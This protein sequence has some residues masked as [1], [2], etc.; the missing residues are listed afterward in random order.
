MKLNTFLQQTESLCGIRSKWH[1]ACSE[2]TKIRSYQEDIRSMLQQVAKTDELD[3]NWKFLHEFS[4]FL[5]AFQK[6]SVL[7]Y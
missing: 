7:L 6:I 5:H 4:H 1:C 3:K 2:S